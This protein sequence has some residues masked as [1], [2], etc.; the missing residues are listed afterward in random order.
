MRWIFYCLQYSACRCHTDQNVNLKQHQET[1]ME[2]HKMDSHQGWM[3]RQIVLLCFLPKQK[4][5]LLE[6]TAASQISALPH[7]S[8]C[9][10]LPPP[11]VFLPEIQ[12]HSSYLFLVGD[13]LLVSGVGL[14]NSGS[15]LP[16]TSSLPPRQ[17][18]S[19]CVWAGGS[20][21]DETKPWEKTRRLGLLAEN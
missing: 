2:V 15:L 18:R 20:V 13:S 1:H 19:L 11:L 7:V 6:F 5:L 17:R 9:L 14:I 10:L 8:R 21:S 12:T 3:D 16:P 4:S